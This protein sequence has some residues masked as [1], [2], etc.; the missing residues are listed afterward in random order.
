MFLVLICA[1]ALTNTEK[2]DQ[3]FQDAD[4][5]E[6]EGDELEYMTTIEPSTP[7]PTPDH[8]KEGK[9]TKNGIIAISCVCGV[10]VI[11]IIIGVICFNNRPKQENVEEQ[12]KNLIN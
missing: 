4:F 2:N 5:I 1:A 3:G 10:G 12:N 6:A 7:S 11:I 8:S 9:I